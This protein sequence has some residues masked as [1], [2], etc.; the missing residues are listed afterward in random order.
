MNRFDLLRQKTRE[1]ILVL[2]G[3][4]G[5]EIQKY[6]LCEED[7]SKG[8]FAAS[9]IPLKGNNDVLAITRPDVIS[10]IHRKYLEA[11]ADII[12]SC[13]FNANSVSQEE[14]GLAGMV[15]QLNLEAAK[16]ARKTA[17]EVERETG[18]VRFVVG[19]IGP[20]GK[21]ASMSPDVENPAA[22]AVTF[23]ELADTYLIAI[24]NLV[25]GGIDG[26]LIETQFDALNTKAAIFAVQEY[27]ERNG[28]DI[29]IMISATIADVSG[30]IL[31]GQKISAF[32]A[33]IAHA[34]PLTVGINCSFG[35]D[36]LAP[37]VEELAA[38]ANC[39]ISCHPNAGL[40]DELGN[41][42]HKPQDM[43]KIIESMAKKGLLNVVGGCCGTTPEHIRAIAEAV[44]N[45]KPRE[46]VR[47]S[48]NMTLCGLEV[49]ELR[50]DTLFV[51]V[52]ERTNVAGSAKFARLIREKNYEEALR[53]ACEQIE[54][55]A[56]IIDV[57]LDDAMLDAEEEM[58]TLLNF[59]A[60]DPSVN[61]VP[62]MLDSSKWEVI[63]AG[64]K[65]SAG[66][67]IVN[68]ISLKEGEEK[69]VEK[70]KR[71]MRFGAAAVIMAFDERGQADTK[72]RKTE[73]SERSYNI[74]RKAGFPEEDIIFDLN[75]FA[76]GTGL[77]EHRRYAVDFIE[78]A[79]EIRK[80][81]PKVHISGGVSNVSFA[82]RGNNQLREAIHSV[83]LYHA[84]KA[85]M[86]MGIVNAGV[87]PIYDEI[88]REL[89][90]RIEDLIFDRKDDAAQRLLDF[91][92]SHKSQ[93]GKEEKTA[94][95]REKPVEERL[96]Y[97]LV[98]GIADCI[99]EDIGE[100]QKTAPSSVSI[101]EGPLMSGMN[102]VGE[103]FGSGQMFLPQ[104]VKSARVMKKAVS[105][106]QPF[107]E[108]EKMDGRASA[109]KILLATV[110]GDV[111]DIGKNI[112]GI[113]LQCNNYEIIDMGVMVSCD[114][115]LDKAQAMNVDAIGLSGLITPSLDEMVSI[116]RKMSERKMN[117]PLIIGGATTS[118]VHTA[119]KIAPE[120]PFGVIQVGDAALIPGVA[121][122]LLSGEKQKYLDEINANYEKLRKERENS[123]SEKVSLEFARKNRL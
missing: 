66:K 38:L 28:V 80:K 40:P 110:K 90:E 22:R 75:I 21:T 100:I 111:H 113:I 85:G 67:T 107:I 101:I 23:D 119:V 44:K 120:Y 114:D 61:R 72:E 31:T 10:G 60:S 104:V 33:S 37:Y 82:F 59:F 108:K 5:T 68:S 15:A 55:G 41:Y 36:L 9:K 121:K 94:R 116:A 70:A 115:I 54:N 78:A 42:T 86:D 43:A 26:V 58:K 56:Q 76:T 93:S 20:T 118:Q 64:L 32:Y 30:R 122:K 29:P 52:G 63:E 35:A 71:I 14:Y 16:L 99:E 39:G 88:D 105:V 3:A 92:Q 96:Q 98:N 69:F 46:I 19:S 34:N 13:T 109:G 51:N 6:G 12:E 18:T 81:Y 106:L 102:K 103:L 7:F 123:Q 47:R 74:L 117:I 83:F 1:K 112:A 8:I 48:A 57:N 87:I 4:M 89:R 2:D 11:G 79:R 95:W 91:S 62:V 17:D 49:F 25:K 77:D 97:S 84:V 24:E 27:N 73:I 50:K 53:L 65:V 45:Y